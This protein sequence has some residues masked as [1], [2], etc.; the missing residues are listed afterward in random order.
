[1]LLNELATPSQTFAQSKKQAK[2]MASILHKGND[3]S[4]NPQKAV[5]DPSDNSVR[6]PG[7]PHINQPSREQ[8]AAFLRNSGFDPNLPLDVLKRQIDISGLPEVSPNADAARRR[9]YIPSHENNYNPLRYYGDGQKRISFGRG[10]QGR[11]WSAEL[12]PYVKAFKKA[13]KANDMQ[14]ANRINSMIYKKT[15]MR[16]GGRPIRTES[17]ITREFFNQLDEALGL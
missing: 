8:A 16:I 4:H 17:K 6:G 10:T 3:D 5:R 1:M 15:G 14:A 7:G 13:F 12:V 11:L 2:R 9:D